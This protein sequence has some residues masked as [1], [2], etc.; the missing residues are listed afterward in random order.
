MNLFLAN[1]VKNHEMALNLKR[2]G[3]PL[4]TISKASGLSIEEIEKL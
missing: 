2:M 1:S 3:V 4:E